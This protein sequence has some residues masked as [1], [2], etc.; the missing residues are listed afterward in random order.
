MKDYREYPIHPLA[1]LFPRHSDEEITELAQ[2]IKEV[3]QLQPIMIAT[4]DKTT[5]LI[6]GRN[7]LAACVEAGIEPKVE[8]Y[9]GDIPAY[10]HSVNLRRD[11]TK[12]QRAMAYAVMFP[13]TTKLKRKLP[14][15]TSDKPSTK[16]LSYCRKVLMYAP[17]L[18]EEVLCGA[19]GLNAAYDIAR[20]AE[21]EDEIKQKRIKEK[22]GQMEYYKTNKPDLFDRINA[23]SITL[24]E[25][26][27]IHKEEQAAKQMINLS[28]LDKFKTYRVF[29]QSVS[30]ESGVQKFIDAIYS[31]D[32]KGEPINELINEL[33]KGVKSM[34]YT[35]QELEGYEKN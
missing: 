9:E 27:A 2:N 23:G 35:I 20:D 28:V 13:E 16:A 17:Q 6:D 15:V 18:Q 21:C 30:S 24:V 31:D 7:R 1:N 19:I 34:Q 12:G 26:N 10:I 25:A 4:E 11:H 22:A 8:V 29:T 32:Y 3:G 33:H 14:Q 5:Y